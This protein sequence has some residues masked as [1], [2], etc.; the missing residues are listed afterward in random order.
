MITPLGDINRLLKQM[1]EPDEYHLA[2]YDLSHPIYW[3]WVLRNAVIN[4][5]P[6]HLRKNV[7]EHAR[8]DVF[9]N[10]QF[11]GPRDYIIEQF[12]RDIIVKFKK[13]N[14][15]YIL[16]TSDVIKLE[17]DFQIKEIP[18]ITLQPNTSTESY[19]LRYIVNEDGSSMIQENG[20]KLFLI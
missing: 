11:I 7:K 9:V 15:D 10:G 5:L 14:F 1:H 20:D 12:G 18:E 19:A 8:F 4:D 17:G 16:E 13:Q 6:P 3:I 2:P